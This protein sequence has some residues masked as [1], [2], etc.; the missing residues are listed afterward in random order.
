LGAAVRKG[1][2]GS[3]VVFAAA[4][5]G[6]EAN[7]NGGEVGREIPFC[8]GTLFSMSSKSMVCPAGSGAQSRDDKR[9]I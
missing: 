8:E 6:S 5:P 2:T 9:A 4:S 1:E 7:G 3:A